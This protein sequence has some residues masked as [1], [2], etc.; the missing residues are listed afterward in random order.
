MQCP[1]CGYNDEGKYNPSKKIQKLRSKRS[2]HTKHLLRRVVNFIQTNVPSDNNL[3][4]EYYF[5]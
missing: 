2:R 3:L 1:C 5:I 4:K